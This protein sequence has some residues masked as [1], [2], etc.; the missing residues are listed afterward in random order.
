MVRPP[1]TASV[2]G[3]QVYGSS[4]TTIYGGQPVYSGTYDQGLVIKML[5]SDQS[6]SEQAIDA[7][8]VLGPKWQEIA[9]KNISTCA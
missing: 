7:R 8:T 6:G 1:G 4:N 5:R 9:T 3:N 2:Y